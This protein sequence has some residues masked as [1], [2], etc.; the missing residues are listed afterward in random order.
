MRVKHDIILLCLLWAATI[1][2]VVLM[3][4]QREP[5]ST[6]CICIV[7]VA[8]MTCLC[9]IKNRESISAD[10]R[11]ALNMTFIIGTFLWMYESISNLVHVICWYI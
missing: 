7:V 11:K 1:V 5:F 4:C 2:D 3:I 6:I 10:V 8:A 9:F